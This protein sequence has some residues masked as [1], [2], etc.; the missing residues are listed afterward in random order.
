LG[1]DEMR[2]EGERREEFLKIN[3]K[4]KTC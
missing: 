2:N 3:Q 4:K 1:G